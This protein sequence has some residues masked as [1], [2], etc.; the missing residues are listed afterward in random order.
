MKTTTVRTTTGLR[1]VAIQKFDGPIFEVGTGQRRE[2]GRYED[3]LDNFCKTYTA[4]TL[5]EIP[6]QCPRR[7]K[8]YERVD[9]AL[10]LALEMLKTEHWSDLLGTVEEVGT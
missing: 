3:C 9:P 2:C 7:C 4:D 6:G 1:R 8:Y 5:G 10:L